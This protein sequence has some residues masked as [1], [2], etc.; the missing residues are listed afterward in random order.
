MKRYYLVLLCHLLVAAAFA[1]DKTSYITIND[2]PYRTAGDDYSMERC[3]LDLYYPQNAKDFATIVWFH[4][5]GL[6]G[7]GKYIPKELQNSGFAVVAVNYRLVPK[8]EF[9]ACIDDAAA[10]VA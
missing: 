7:G 1:Q 2:L 9:T 10:A 4:G 8:C 5:G 6:T 3:K